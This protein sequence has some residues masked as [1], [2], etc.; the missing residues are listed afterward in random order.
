M[1]ILSMHPKL[2]AQRNETNEM[3]WNLIEPLN[4]KIFYNGKTIEKT[5]FCNKTDLFDVKLISA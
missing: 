2:I 1:I 4:Y 5:T 3:I